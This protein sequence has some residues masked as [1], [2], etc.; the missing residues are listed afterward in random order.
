MEEA[1]KPD[2]FEHSLGV[3]YT[4]ASM[5]MRFGADIEKALIAGMLHDCAKGLSHD[6]QMKICV[7]HDLPVSDCER[8]N[9]KLLHAKVGAY[10]AENKYGITDPEILSAITWHTTGRPGMT[11][12]EKI[13]FLA[14]IIEPSRRQFPELNEL[15][16]AIFDD[17]N[18][19]LKLTLK[20]LIIYLNREAGEIDPKTE[21]TCEYYN[22]R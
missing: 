14:D 10:L 6:E 4:A 22:N 8:R 18:E 17:L 13:I 11:L 16:T 2:R 21:E 7:K 15:R 19:G 20:H 3:A 5:A 12:L 9:P 1:L